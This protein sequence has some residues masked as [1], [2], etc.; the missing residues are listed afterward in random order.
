MRGS[1]CL[2]INKVVT[3]LSR[4]KSI[5]GA[6]HFLILNQLWNLGEDMNR[7]ELFFGFEENRQH[8]SHMLK[9]WALVASQNPGMQGT[10]PEDIWLEW[11]HGEQRE[12][13]QALP[14]RPVLISVLFNIFISDWR[15]GREG[16]T[17]NDWQ[18]ED[19]TSSW[20]A[21]SAEISQTRQHTMKTS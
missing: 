12:L 5:G 20:W 17:T 14:Q 9:M 2:E 18:T 21:G 13:S 4:N 1:N 7:L 3:M 10:N 6:P 11:L 15:K 8:L 19:A 16:M